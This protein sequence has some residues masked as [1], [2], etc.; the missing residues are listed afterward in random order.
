MHIYIYINK[1]EINKIMLMQGN[2]G[3]TYPLDNLKIY[4]IK[5]TIIMFQLFVD[6]IN[7]KIAS[8]T[9]GENHNIHFL[10]YIIT[11]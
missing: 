5:S 4:G 1:Y 11:F 7:K 10:K 3:R 9:F 8:F 6:E 2:L